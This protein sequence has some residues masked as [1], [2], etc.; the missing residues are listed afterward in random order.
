MSLLFGAISIATLA[1]RLI[2]VTSS[3]MGRRNA[4]RGAR[5]SSLF[6]MLLFS[7]YLFGAAF[8]TPPVSDAFAQTFGTFAPDV[9]AG[10]VK[11]TLHLAQ[12][13]GDVGGNFSH[14]MTRIA[15]QALAI[16]SSS[17]WS[18]D[19][20]V[21]SMVLHGLHGEE[22]RTKLFIVDDEV[23]SGTRIFYPCISKLIPNIAA[24]E[25]EIT[26]SGFRAVSRLLATASLMAEPRLTAG[27]SSNYASKLR[28]F[29]SAYVED[30]NPSQ[31]EQRAFFKALFRGRQT[32]KR[33]EGDLGRR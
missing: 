27:V 33:L 7:P 5:R 26:F 25:L 4:S 3:S 23:I 6:H 28:G 17:T 29:F 11:A 30:Q 24:K 1:W 14:E 12:A 16:A 22:P 8:A 13:S 32:F 10:A 9:S 20:A 19:A 31:E 2:T 15:P 21:S 18:D